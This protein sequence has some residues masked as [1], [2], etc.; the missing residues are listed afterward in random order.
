MN[1][2]LSATR[3]IILILISSYSLLLLQLREKCV[4]RRN[5]P[6]NLLLLS[7]LC[8]LL[9]FIIIMTVHIRDNLLS[10]RNLSPLITSERG[11]KR[12]A[13]Y[14]LLSA[15]YIVLYLL[16][17]DVKTI[18]FPFSLFPLSSILPSHGMIYLLKL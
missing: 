17:H 6:R 18:S 1:L 7:L 15:T 5:V 2:K 11:N 13:R 16:Y 14:N 3:P 10:F 12:I 4:R 8:L 9:Q